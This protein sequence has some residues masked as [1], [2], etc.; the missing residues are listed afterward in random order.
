MKSNRPKIQPITI[1]SIDVTNGFWYEKQKLVENVSMQNVYKRFYETGRFEAFKHNWVLERDGEEKKPHVFWDSDVAKWIE[2]VG[3]ISLKKRVP[4]LEK[5]VDEVVDDIEKNAMSDGYFNSYFTHLEP[6]S[7][8]TRRNDHELYCLGHLIEAAIAYKRGTGKDKFYL[9]MKKYAD[10]VYKIFYVEKSAVFLTPGHEE[11]ELA[12]VKLY[13]ESGEKK[14]LD[15]SLHFVDTRGT[16]NERD[17]I[18]NAT[19]LGMQDHLPVRRQKTAEGHAVRAC[20]LYSAVADLAKETEDEELYQTARAL[21]DSITKKRMYVTGAVG[22]TCVREAFMG[23]YDLPNQ[24]AY[25]ETCANLS[26]A[27]FARRMSFIEPDSVYADT[28]ER[29][30]YNSFISGMSL[31]GKS[32]FY[33]NMQENNTIVKTREY[34]ARHT[35]FTPDD[36]R[37]EVFNCSCCPPNVVRSIASIQ[38]FQYS[39]SENTVFMHQ[40]IGSEAKLDDGKISVSTEYPFDGTVNIEYIGA[41]VTLA[42]RIPAWCKKYEI[43]CN[44]SPIDFDVKLG[45]AY[46]PIEEKANV[47]VKFDMPV[48]FV[49]AHPRVFE[50]AGR[51]VVTKGPIVYCMEAVDHTAPIR[52]IRL[53]KEAEYVQVNDMQLKVPVLETKGYA[54]VWNVDDLYSDEAAL[55]AVNVKLIPYFAFANRGRTDMII[56]TLKA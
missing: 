32:F 37:V 9:L 39:R 41:P 26:L 50:D 48:R 6:E 2:A 44:G 51:I 46:L 55:E 40:Y 47:T 14:Y 28:V 53:D 16:D 45:Y 29:V 23:D 52:D 25:A 54:R 43:T 8:F 31:D 13:R 21:F 1:E 11:I 42:L 22:Q 10:L 34:G 19:L 56:W 36:T 15:L 7:R 49:E 27:L 20:Y 24:T 17:R 5:I 35:V 18:A 33:S 3:Y 4:E 12:L 38:D 30:L